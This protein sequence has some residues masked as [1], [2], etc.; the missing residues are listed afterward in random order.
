M[1]FVGGMMWI[2]SVRRVGD[3]GAAADLEADKRVWIVMARSPDEAVSLVRRDGHAEP[4]WQL[5]V[6]PSAS[7]TAA[8][9]PQIV[10]PVGPPT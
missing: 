1:I 6:G 10:F 2:F 4:I 9:E 3:T 8:V 7:P 5:E